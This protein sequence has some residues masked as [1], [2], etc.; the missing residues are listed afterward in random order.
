MNVPQIRVPAAL[1][2]GEAMQDRISAILL[3]ANGISVVFMFLMLGLRVGSLPDSVVL[4][5]DA[6]GSPNGWGP[7][8]VLW[9]IPLIALGVTLMNA[10]LAWFLAPMD[11]FASRFVLAGALVVQLVAW[12]ALFDFL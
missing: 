11:R 10:V 2:Q 12:V 9:R 5:I 7:P 3:A 4:H 6:A 8:S 1:A